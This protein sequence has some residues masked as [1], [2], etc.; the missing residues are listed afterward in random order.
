[1]PKGTYVPP[2]ARQFAWDEKKNRHNISKH[3]F[4]FVDAEEMF[5]GILL[6]HPDMRKD[7]G[8]RRWVGI[9]STRGWIAM[10]AFAESVPETIRII[11]LRKASRRDRKEYEKAIQNGLEAN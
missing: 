5:R 4:D 3:G 11:S 6:A 7:Y 1:M 10:V 2:T 9:G 8:E